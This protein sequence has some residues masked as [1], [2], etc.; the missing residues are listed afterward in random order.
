MDGNFEGSE[1]GGG[2]LDE[3]RKEGEERC[4]GCCRK[5][6]QKSDFILTRGTYMDPAPSR[7][8]LSI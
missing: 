2:L 4:K 1:R 8:I 3:G 7:S 5:N 6:S